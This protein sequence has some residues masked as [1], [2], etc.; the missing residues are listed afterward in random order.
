[1]SV[2]PHFLQSHLDYFS[3]KCGDLSEEQGEHF[4][5]DICIMEKC[6]YDQW[7]EK[8]LTTA[9]T[10]WDVV[11]LQAQAEVPEKTFYP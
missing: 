3:K 5:Q 4:H 10:K 1:M 9:G 8:S 2:K 11:A 7:D 6:Y